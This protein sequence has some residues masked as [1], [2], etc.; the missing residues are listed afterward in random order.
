[1]L[2]GVLGVGCGWV[3]R[4]VSGVSRGIC[5]TG[6]Q[7]ETGTTMSIEARWQTPEPSNGCAHELFW[8]GSHSPIVECHYCGLTWVDEEPK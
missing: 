5:W 6:R 7:R 4:C 8:R 3:R 2:G 1:M